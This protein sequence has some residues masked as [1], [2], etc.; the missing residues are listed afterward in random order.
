MLYLQLSGSPK[1]IAIVVI[2]YYILNN[3]RINSRIIYFGKEKEYIPRRNCLKRLAVELVRPQLQGR[4]L[5][6]NLSRVLQ[7]LLEKY[8]PEAAQPA[9]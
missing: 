7:V 5:Y 8:S 1:K 2:F 4:L 6:T 3:A 9:N